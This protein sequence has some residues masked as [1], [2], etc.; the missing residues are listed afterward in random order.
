LLVPPRFGEGIG[1]CPTLLMADACQTSATPRYN[2]FKALCRSKRASCWELT[3]AHNAI[4][5]ASGPGKDKA[6]ETRL[7]HAMTH[8]C[9]RPLWVFRDDPPMR[10]LG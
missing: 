1:Y 6:A 5:E 8:I 4:L 9:L 2:E 3:Q 10:R 7:Q